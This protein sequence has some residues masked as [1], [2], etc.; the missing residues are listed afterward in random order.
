MTF[1]LVAGDGDFAGHLPADLEGE[2]ITGHASLDGRRRALSRTKSQASNCLEGP[3]HFCSLLPQV[4]PNVDADHGL[5]VEGGH[6]PCPDTRYVRGDE[7]PVDP[8][9][10]LHTAAREHQGYGDGP[11]GRSHASLAPWRKPSPAWRAL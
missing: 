1:H 7:G 8:V 11:Q 3:S 5:T 4:E 10:L 2:H 6:G 9:L